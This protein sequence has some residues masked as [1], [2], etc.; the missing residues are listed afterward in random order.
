M[1]TTNPGERRRWN[2]PRWTSIWPRRE[3]LTSAVTPILLRHVPATAAGRVLEVGSGGGTATLAL[4]TTA[5]RVVGADIS[6]ALCG[7]ARRRAAAEKVGNVEFVVADVQEE[8]VPGGPFDAAVSQFGVMFFDEPAR[9]FA[10]IRSQLRAGGSLVFACWQEQ[11]RNP[12]A[13]NRALVPFVPAPAPP[14]PGKSATGPFS[15]AEPDATSALLRA[16]GWEGVSREAHELVVDIDAAAL[17]GDD[18]LRFAGVAPERMDD[19]RD[20]VDAHLAPLRRPDGRYDAPLAF[21]VFV[22]RAAG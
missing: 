7:L 5:G 21:Q 8:A 2:D 19:A 9:A 3:R 14:G 4:A 6:E 18:Y 22:A 12:W 1:N 11:A 20:A 13:V 17:A 10:N 15:L 16:A